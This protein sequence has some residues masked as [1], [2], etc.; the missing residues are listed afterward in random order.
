MKPINRTEKAALQIVWLWQRMI[1][2]GKGDEWR[3]RGEKQ[4]LRDGLQALK[5]TGAI[6]DFAVNPPRIYSEGR[7]L[8]PEDVA[9]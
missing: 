1:D 7:E 3:F 2:E 8:T 6:D 9:P 4:G 5:N